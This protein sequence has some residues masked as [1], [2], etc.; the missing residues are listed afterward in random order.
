MLHGP[1]G[2]FNKKTSCMT[3]NKCTKRFVLNCEC[4]N[5]E[6]KENIQISKILWVSSE[7]DVMKFGLYFLFS[8][9]KEFNQETQTVSIVIQ[10]I[11]KEVWKT[12]VIHVLY[13]MDLICKDKCSVRKKKCTED[14]NSYCI[15][16]SM[17]V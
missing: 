7:V 8:F 4:E 9:P 13:K 17:G 14:W 11:V 5:Y 1:C 3:D 16:Y 15:K 10:F 2:V 6:R 12:V